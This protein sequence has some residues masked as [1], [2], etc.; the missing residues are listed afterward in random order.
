MT[1][2]DLLRILDDLERLL[3]TVVEQPDAEAVR[4]CHEALQEALA[5]PERA[6]RGPEVRDR[7]QALK[8]VLDQRLALL[9][10]ARDET[11]RDLAKGAQAGRALSA[12]RRG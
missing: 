2:P 1:D 11:R 3:A 8:R 4:R 7:A 6:P 9:E 12:Y 5:A 10:A